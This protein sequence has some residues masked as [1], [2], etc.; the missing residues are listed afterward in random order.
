[1]GIIRLPERA[2]FFIGLLFVD[3]AIRE[4]V[5]DIFEKKYGDIYRCSDDFP[6][7]HTEYYTE[8]LGENIKRQFIVF[9]DLIEKDTLADRKLF[10]NEIEDLLSK[11]GKRVINIDPGYLDLS[12]LVL[13]STKDFSHRMY[14]RNGIYAEVTCIYEHGAFQTFPWT[15]PDYKDVIT[16]DFFYQIRAHYYSLVRPNKKRSRRK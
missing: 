3:N 6:F 8:E 4:K 1:M 11:N 14:L 15:Y 2:L 9:K 7:T 16:Q 12:K 10:S 13:A 5:I